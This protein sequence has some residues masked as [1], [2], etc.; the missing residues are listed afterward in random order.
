MAYLQPQARL[1]D[2]TPRI[3]TMTVMKIQY[4]DSLA[5]TPERTEISRP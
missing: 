1:V 3:R 2:Y 5:D 4:H